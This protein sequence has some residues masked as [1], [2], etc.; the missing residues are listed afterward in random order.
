MENDSAMAA[1]NAISLLAQT[2]EYYNASRVDDFGPIFALAARL[3]ALHEQVLSG[4][5]PPCVLAELM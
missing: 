2:V 3:C 4:A 5:T 1:A